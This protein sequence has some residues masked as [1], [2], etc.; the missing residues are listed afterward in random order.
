MSVFIKE[1]LS[2]PS[3]TYSNTA[4]KYDAPPAKIVMAIIW[5]HQT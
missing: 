3:S 5:E 1:E 2:A 4:S